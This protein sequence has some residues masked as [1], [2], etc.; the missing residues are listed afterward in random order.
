[1]PKILIQFSRSSVKTLDLNS[2]L[3]A[4]DPRLLTPAQ[5]RKL[6]NACTIAVDGYTCTPGEMF[7][8]PEARR[9]MRHLFR[10]WPHWLFFCSLDDYWLR[11]MTLCLME[12]IIVH[13][14]EEDFFC[15]IELDRA[16]VCEWLGFAIPPLLQL[17]AR[18]RLS[19]RQISRHLDAVFNYFELMPEPLSENEGSGFCE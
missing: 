13:E 19:P 2:F 15:T 3:Q 16:E 10:Q 7:V 12:D 11:A 9:F 5:L 14:D 4:M 18:A 8:I 6:R 1:M 17:C